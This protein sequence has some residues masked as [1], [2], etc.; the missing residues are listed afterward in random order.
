[1]RTYQE[2]LC[3]FGPCPN[4]FE[5]NRRRGTFE[6]PCMFCAE[7][8]YD[9]YQVRSYLSHI[10]EMATYLLLAVCWRRP[11]ALFKLR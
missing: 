11:L 6:E 1:M 2:A 3:N 5:W 4:E 10:P 7:M 8:P 9:G